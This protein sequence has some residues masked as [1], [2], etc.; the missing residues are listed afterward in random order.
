MSNKLV[1]FLNGQSIVEYD[2]KIRLPGH[3]RQYLDKMDSDMDAGIEI[4][5][6]H[7]D[8]P[9]LNQR[10]QYIAMYLVQAILKNN[11]AM[12][13]AMSAYLAN[14]LPELKQLKALEQGDNI[15]VDLVFNEEDNNKVAVQFDPTITTKH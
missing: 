3:Q 9:D 10:A 13:A 6:V 14:R 5:G 8:K 15:S 1:V 12:I 11:E 4:N 2:R 7:F